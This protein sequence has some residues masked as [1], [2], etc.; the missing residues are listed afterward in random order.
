MP[1]SSCR[2]SLGWLRVVDLSEG[3]GAAYCARL[4]HD[5]GARVTHLGPPLAKPAGLDAFLRRGQARG[6]APATVDVLEG[7]LAGVQVL[8]DDGRL[9]DDA[10]TRLR[11]TH[12][13]LVLVCLRPFGLGTGP[14]RPATD[15]TLQAYAGVASQH[16]LAERSP[17]WAAGEL[18]GWISGSY[19]AVAALAAARRSA[20]QGVGDFVDLSTA[21][22]L[23]ATMTAVMSVWDSLGGERPRDPER[24]TPLP[25]VERAADGYIGIVTTQQQTFDAFL[26]MIGRPD[27][28]GEPALAHPFARARQR[29]R[30]Q[31]SIDDWFL[32]RSRAE[33]AAEAADRRLPVSE[34]LAPADLLSNEHYTH[35]RIYQADEHGVPR[36][37]SPLVYDGVLPSA[38]EPR[39][40]R[41]P[42][43]A[44]PDA[45]LP[46]QGLRVLDLSIWWAGSA[47]TQLLAA[48]GADVVKVESL[49]HLD[50][51]RHRSA[52][53]GADRWWEWSWL[54]AAANTGKR[55]VTLDA[56]DP[57]GLAAIWDLVERS[58]I[59]LENFT[60]GVLDGW[61]LTWA[62]IR[63]RAPGTSLVQMPAFG[64]DGPWRSRRGFDPTISQATGLA[65]T[66]G[67]ADGPPMAPKSICDPLV[68]IHAAFAA[69]VA[70]DETRQS[71]RGHHVECAMSDV[72]ATVSAASVQASVTDEGEP[73]RR[74][75]RG[76]DA[77][78][79]LYAC[80]GDDAWLA[81]AV[82]SEHAWR[83]L[84]I[85]L[86]QEGWLAEELLATVAGRRR[87]HDRLDEV[88]GAWAA[89]RDA[90]SAAAALRAHGVAAERLRSVAEAAGSEI[91][92]GRGFVEQVDRAVTGPV[93]LPG[94][95]F[96]MASRPGPWH[97]T[98]AP[99]LG[100]HNKD[101]LC[102]Q[103][104]RSQQ[105]WQ[106]MVDRG[107]VGETP[108]PVDG[109][110][111]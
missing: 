37:R 68:G 67:Y 14:E 55:S 11:R 61:G 90:E 53:P 30:L 31:S 2:S 83:G 70:W 24:M 12:P 54:Y 58:D 91:F 66:S 78:Q 80:D 93:D 8:I 10:R 64:L 88:I 111:R 16:G 22:A 87:A 3:L 63:R 45:G 107:T 96:R 86:G 39:E 33:I 44:S 105:W 57:D 29:S 82:D 41:L 76:E 52:R 26:A 50:G 43:A 89:G 5:A 38:P 48:L 62:E 94:L 36:P 47:A 60:P 72:M 25:G 81:V 40:V 23:F 106:E 99:R 18:G 71:G 103:L 56:R 97:R 49:S 28:L 84:C 77:P 15:F 100:Q 9:D 46:L 92:A 32:P 98:P 19:A 1:T 108:A 79:G 27:L 69:L 34:V 95:P 42:P 110:T 74:G 20:T 102:E 6:P 85:A 4:L 51:S 13:T 65:W 73:T 101:V 109:A 59:V 7:Q 21:E 104:E 75:N 35:R 17:L